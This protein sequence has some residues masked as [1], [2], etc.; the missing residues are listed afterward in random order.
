[1]RLRLGHTHCGA[2]C[3]GC[4]AVLPVTSN[5]HQDQ[6]GIVSM[7]CVAGGCSGDRAGRRLRLTRQN[8]RLAHISLLDPEQAS[9][10]R[11]RSE[12]LRLAVWMQGSAASR[13]PPHRAQIASVRDRNLDR[14]IRVFR[15]ASA[16]N[17]VAFF[18]IATRN[19]GG[20]KTASPGI[21]PPRR[22]IQASL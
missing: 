8:P 2:R 3:Q 12:H 9:V 15:H 14:P 22:T 13:Q 19:M 18:L 16:D 5:S 20:N 6:P 11:E 4:A 21:R 7:I 10:H 1:M 17:G